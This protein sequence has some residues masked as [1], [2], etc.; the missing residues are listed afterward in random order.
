MIEHFLALSGR[1]PLVTCLRLGAIWLKDS[2]IAFAEVQVVA[3]QL[4]GRAAAAA[5]VGTVSVLTFGFSLD[6]EATLRA[7]CLIR[8]R[9]RV[10]LLL[11][12]HLV[13]ENLACRLLV[14]GVALLFATFPF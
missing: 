10:S 11:R 4:G 5:A 1:R 12:F 7:P 2:L 9:D 8:L 3:G 13:G 14:L 6:I